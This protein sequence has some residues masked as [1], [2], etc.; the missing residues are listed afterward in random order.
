MWEER[1]EAERGRKK[2]AWSTPP[3]GGE[4]RSRKVRREEREGR[5]RSDWLTLIWKEREREREIC[6]IKEELILR[7]KMFS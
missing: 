1:R 7:N 6:K 5:R 4:W 2:G 3:T